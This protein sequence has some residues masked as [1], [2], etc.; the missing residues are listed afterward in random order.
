MNH[1][2]RLLTFVVGFMCMLL[3][4]SACHRN[5]EVETNPYARLSKLDMKYKNIQII[6]FTISSRGVQETDN[7]QG[8]LADAQSNCAAELMKSNLFENV[9][10]VSTT[11]RAD[12]TLI[13]QGELT[14]LRI[15]GTGAR[16]WLGGMAGRSE[17]AIHVKLIDATTGTVV[18]ERDIRDDTNPS[19]GAYSAGATDKMLP[20]QVGG[21]IAGYVIDTSRKQ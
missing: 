8:V 3:V 18:G 16:I 13:V 19:A 15:V 12:A 10:Y 17:M 5:N 2:M 4:A 1:R 14:Q 11:E 21:L 9:K 7:P 20:Q 6:N